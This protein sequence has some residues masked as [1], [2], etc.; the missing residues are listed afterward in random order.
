MGLAFLF[1]LGVIPH[2]ITARV[3][4]VRQNV[5]C[6]FETAANNGDTCA[7][8]AAGWGLTE[9]GFAAINPGVSCP[10]NLV[11]GQNYCVIGTGTA[12]TS[13][14]STAKTTSS[15]GT[16]VKAT[17]SSTS[18]KVSTT[19]VTTTTSSSGHEPTQS[20]LAANCNNFHLVTSGDTCSVIES[21]YDI[22]AADFASWNPFID[23]SKLIDY[24]A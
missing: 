2:L 4:Q 9:S 17:T 23:S 20:G 5:E 8:F 1:A 22:S 16:T 14:T 21:E 12:A 13:T 11:A 7:S 18:T 3:L 24:M 10:G 19:P 6:D 15:V